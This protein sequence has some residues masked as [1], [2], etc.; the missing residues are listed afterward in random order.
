MNWS[1]SELAALDPAGLIHPPTGRDWTYSAVQV[2]LSGGQGI[3]MGT[4]GALA[5]TL[6]AAGGVA[7]L[8]RQV[9]YRWPISRSEEPGSLPGDDDLPALLGGGDLRDQARDFA[10]TMPAAE[11]LDAFRLAAAVQDPRRGRP[12]SLGAAVRLPRR[13]RPDRRSR[14]PGA[15]GPAADLLRQR[16]RRR[17]RP[18][19]TAGPFSPLTA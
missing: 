5:R 4:I 6:A 18:G 1:L 19:R 14:G 8:A 7:P 12:G 16:P 17:A 9:E 13:P 11:L 15:R 10:M 3:D 2:M